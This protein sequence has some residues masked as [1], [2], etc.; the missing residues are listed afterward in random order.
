MSFVYGDHV[1]TSR[2][3]VWEQLTR[4]GSTRK[5]SWI[6]IGDFNE[7]TGNQEKRGGNLRSAASFVP[8]NLMIQHC[9][10]LEFSCYGDQMSWRGRRGK[11]IVRCRLDRALGNEDFHEL[12][13]CSKVNY[14]DMIGSDHRPVL[15]N[16]LKSQSYTRRQFRFDKRWIGKDGLAETVDMGW[17]RTNNFRV[18]RFVD[19]IKNCR[20]AISW[21]RNN[22]IPTGQA[23][24][25]SL[26]IALEEAKNDDSIPQ[27]EI[28]K[29]AQ[30]LKE[31]YHEEEIYW[32]QKSRNLWLK[33]GDKNTKIFHASTKQRR[34]RNKISGLF[35]SD[36]IWEE[37]EKG[38]EDIASG[39]FR[40]LFSKSNTSGIEETVQVLQPLITESMN[41]V[42]TKV[43]TE[44]EVKNALFAMHPEK[45]PG[46]DGMTALFYQRFWYSIKDD[47]VQMVKDFFNSENF[48]QRLNET[49]I[50]LIPK[51]EKPQRMADFRP[52]SLCNV[53]YKIISKNFCLR[54][55]KFLPRLISDT[56]SVFVSGRLITDNILIA[57]EMFHGLRTIKVCRE[58]FLAIKTDMSKAYD[59]IEWSFLEAVL[60]RL[61]FNSV[62]ISWIMWSVSSVSYQVLMNGQ[63]KGHIVPQR[64]IRQGD[65]LSPY[66]FILCTEVL[67]ANIKKVEKDKKITGISIARACPPI[68]HLLFADDSLF[69]CKAETEECQTVLDVI[70]RYGRAYG[71]EINFNKSSVMFGNKIT[72]QIKSQLKGL[73][74]ITKE[75]GINN[76]LGIPES[77]GGSKCKIFNYVRERLNERINGWSSNFLSKGGK[78]IMIKSVALALPS[79]VMSCFKIPQDLTY[80]LSSAI[81][82]YWWSSNGKDR[83]LHWLAWEKMCKPK[84]DG[85]MGF[86][87]LE[88]YNDAML[89]KQYWRLIQYP[90]SLLAQVLK[91]RYYRKVHPLR[92]KKPYSPSFGW[93]SI[94]STKD[95]VQKGTRWCLGSGRDISVWKDLWI[96]DVNPRPANGR[97]REDY[98]NMKV[99]QLINPV[100]K[101]WYLPV[102]QYYMDLEDVSLIRRLPI[103][104][105]FKEDRLIWHY[106]K[107]G[108]YTVKSGYELAWSM[109]DEVSSG[110]SSKALKAQ[111]WKV[112]APPKIK[113]M[114]W[115]I[116]S[117]TLAVTSRLNH[118]GVKCDSICQRCGLKEETIN[119]V[120]FECSSAVQTWTLSKVSSSIINFPT[121][122]EYTNLDYLYWRIPNNIKEQSISGCFPWI[123]WFLWKARNK[124]LFEGK[125]TLPQDILNRAITEYLAWEEAQKIPTE[126]EVNRELVEIIPS[127]IRCRIDGSLKSSDP[128][129]GLGWVCIQG[130]DNVLLLGAK[131]Y[132][133]TLSPLHTELE[134]LL[135]AVTSIISAK[136][137]C[138]VFETDCADL[139]AMVQSPEE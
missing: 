109:S 96:P 120:F 16:F 124:K 41:R 42:L 81:S 26:K 49:N 89:A 105:S 70:E 95:L 78:E 85:G 91:G 136:I 116:A 43:I 34:V 71:Q 47:L 138:H 134:A 21:W 107:S 121:G 126:E 37:S 139:V 84:S 3:L 131:C 31:A 119:H 56:Q 45:A 68:S 87:C 67:I 115:Q 73:I 129:T 62:W 52:I 35:G 13:P 122:S 93:K 46:P 118:R 74:G 130:D 86:R 77:L 60:H 14:L 99:E 98:P 65:P 88:K 11:Q 6:M 28:S 7:L 83:G 53:S 100:S 27:E 32:Q 76:Y 30:K 55:K 17:N 23:N 80:K 57:H 127:L 1:A 18:P 110:P 133:K 9:G 44:K 61:G 50:W 108:K 69:F 103:S 111:A 25:A 132:R 114:L 64:G 12:Y 82:K 19:K 104:K 137:L 5:A 36:N 123:L 39:Y 72:D 94:F 125:Q 128:T 8:F 20:N 79:Y 22:N 66:L 106:T 63:P 92:A 54:L 33:V 4:I 135:W 15:L 75:G 102:L 10:M 101:V 113:H 58:K 29:I 59:R 97:G 51:K 2:D 40:E 24:I 90:N 117:G 112:K 38:M 48:D